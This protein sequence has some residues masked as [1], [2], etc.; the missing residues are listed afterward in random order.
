M[1]H[2]R[3]RRRLAVALLTAFIS[4]STLGCAGPRPHYLPPAP[5]R[6]EKLDDGGV[7]RIY[8]V[9]GDGQADYA[10]RISPQGRI[11]M[12]RY[13]MNGDG[14]L[15]ETVIRRLAAGEIAEGS[16]AVAAEPDRHLV[17]ILDSL[18]YQLV[19]DAWDRGRFRDFE[20]P[21]RVISPFPVMT[22]LSLS[23]F[24]GVSP[25]PGVESA[26]YDGSRLTDGYLTYAGEKNAPWVTQT[27][28]YLQFLAHGVGYLHP[29]RWYEHELGKIQ[30]Y[31]YRSTRPL[32]IGYVVSTSGLGAWEGAGGHQS[33]IVRLDRFCQHVVYTLRGRVQITLFSDHGHAITPS[34]RIPLSEM[35]ERM[36]YRVSSRLEREGD[37]VVPEFGVVNCAA[38]HTRSA[39]RV[40]HDLLGLEG[41]E[42]TAYMEEG[43]EVVVCGQAGTARIRIG[44]PGDR[45][46]YDFT[47]GDPLDLRDV[48]R[49]L[50][51][52]GRVDAQ[53]FVADADLFQATRGHVYPDAVHRLWRAF[54]GLIAHA[55]D[56]LISVKDGRHCG[57]KFMSWICDVQAAHGNLGRDSTYGFVMTTAGT[58]PEIV[59]MERLREELVR[60][61]VPMRATGNQ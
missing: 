23:E 1:L 38:I 53:G 22:D 44:L 47:D 52:N 12:L 6:T 60:L 48:W 31:F 30:R 45:Y 61:G 27:D 46:R 21:V 32:F 59:R 29:D 41:I 51:D 58:L 15:E 35:L 54:H 56:V 11:V 37:V 28:Y 24:F 9:N 20:P 50:D 18:P 42:H 10:E 49:Q 7:D 14:G 5:L 33:A 17:I 19:R 8:D 55:P 13:D 26:Y 25:A 2:P 4:T 39:P 36:G 3:T 57:S 40:A 43:G 34:R 16:R